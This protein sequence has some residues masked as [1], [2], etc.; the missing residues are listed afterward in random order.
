[1]IVP[2]G[3]LVTVSG[4]QGPPGGAGPPGAPLEILGSVATVADLPS[5]GQNVGDLW[6]VLADGHGYTWDGIAW[7]DCGEIQS[8]VPGPQGPA[9]TDGVDGAAATIAVGTVVT[10]AEGSAV[11]ITNS[12]N[13]TAAVFDFSIPRGDTGAQGIQGVPGQDSTVAGPAGS[14]GTDGVTPTIT[15]GTVTTGLAGSSVIITDSGTAPN[16]VFNFT[17]PRGDVGAVG[18]DGPPGPQGNAGADST[19]PGPKGD[20]GD[21]GLTGAQGAKGDQG[22]PGPT[23]ADGQ[24]INWLGNWSPT[25]SYAIY[26]AVAYNGSCY[27]GVNSGNLN[28]VPD[29]PSSGYWN[30][31]AQG[32]IWKGDWAGATNYTFRDI[33]FYD[34]S[35]Y[36]AIAQSN[37]VLPDSDASKWNLLAQKGDQGDPGRSGTDFGWMEQPVGYNWMGGKPIYQYTF[38]LSAVTAGLNTRAHSIPNIQEI[39]NIFAQIYDSN[40]NRWYP[41]VFVDPENAQNS[42]STSADKTNYYFLTHSGNTNAAAL[43]G[44]VTLQYICTDR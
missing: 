23:G 29:T 25:V 18:A 43:S 28:Q 33:V 7:V 42:F 11:T 35:A 2:Y 39:V 37:T 30:L 41:A 21:V 44:Q 17:I 15:V 16:A 13:N 6:V 36:I 3:S 1:M 26:D 40:L 12:G 5:S 8:T 4:P 9:G 34:G 22:D 19:V 24:S 10:G 20:Q 32:V 27:I 38:D 31:M 14:D